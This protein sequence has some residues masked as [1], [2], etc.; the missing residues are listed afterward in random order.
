MG[1]QN[2]SMSI[3]RVIK[4]EGAVWVI[5]ESAKMPMGEAI[6]EA[7]VEKGTLLVKKRTIRQGPVAIDLVLR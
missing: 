4:D 7:V 5:T 3:N 2:M 6:D 1:P